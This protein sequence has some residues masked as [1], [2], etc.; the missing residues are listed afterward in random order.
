MP[1]LGLGIGLGS[2][3]GRPS[4]GGS[5]VPSFA[6]TDLPDLELW[7]DAEEGA[8][9]TVGNYFTDENAS[10]FVVWSGVTGGQTVPVANPGF[11]NYYTE[12]RAGIELIVSYGP[13]KWFVEGYD[14]SGE[15]IQYL[16]A[17]EASVGTEQYPWQATWPANVTVTRT[18]TTLDVPATNNQTVARWVNKVSGKPNLNQ[19]T[20]AAQPVFKSD[21]FGRKA[22]FFDGDALF[23]S[24]FSPFGQAYSY[25]LVSTS[26]LGSTNTALHPAIR[27]GSS[28]AASGWRGMFGA[29]SGDLAVQN[30]STK[31]NPNNF[32]GREIT[33]NFGVFSAR[34]RILLGEAT[35][36]RNLV[37]SLVEG[38]S[39]SSANTNIII[40]GAGNTFGST[41]PIDSNFSEVLVYRATHDDDTALQVINYLVQK[42]NI[43][44]NL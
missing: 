29:D 4:I 7:L 9:N 8:I 33:N 28:T 25:Y 20:L 42:W 22:V 35:I 12:T 19:T 26:L 21:V 1:K 27:I 37:S 5:I 38:L 31:V 40:I 34:F 32:L 17:I 41:R 15:D 13:D 10:I 30:S 36:S 44:T 43:D 18:A 6:P 39:V 24:G 3:I 23:N 14:V 2:L 16:G 11:R